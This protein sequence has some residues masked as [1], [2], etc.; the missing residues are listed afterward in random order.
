MSQL[1]PCLQSGDQVINF[2]HLVWLSVSAGQLTGYMAQNIIDS[3]EKE[4]KVLD[5]AHKLS[6][7]YLV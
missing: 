3:P 5:F 2:F 7:F 6:L 1:K 4:V